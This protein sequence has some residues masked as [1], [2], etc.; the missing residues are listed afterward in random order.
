MKPERLKFA[1]KIKSAKT[2]PAEIL[3][4]LEAYKISKSEFS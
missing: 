1:K 4:E 2:L 3:T